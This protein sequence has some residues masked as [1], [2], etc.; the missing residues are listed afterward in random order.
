MMG[1]RALIVNHSPKSIWA[2]AFRTL[3]TKIIYSKS[4]MVKSILFTS[5][6]AGEGKSITVANTA[7][8][9]AQTNKK[10]IVVD[11]DLRKPV[12]YKIFKKKKTSRGLTNFLTGECEIAD[13]VQDT[14]IPNLR[15]VTSGPL[16]VNPSELLDSDKFKEAISSLKEQADYI[17]IDSPPVL[18]VTDSCIL[19][20]KMDGI[21]LVVGVE[22][23][24]PEMALR[25][26]EHLE[27]VDGNILGIIIN[28][29]DTF[30]EQNAYF[31]YCGNV[32]NVAN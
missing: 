7:V 1:N 3:R 20:S 12:Q 32:G 23:V 8:V 29:S 27:A 28:R 21:I 26:K 18:A 4:G 2:E 14:D 9:L 19:G 31:H 24:Q 5:A 25:A 17:I 13:I 6:S 11:C 10:V 22:K 15:L 30:V 16:L